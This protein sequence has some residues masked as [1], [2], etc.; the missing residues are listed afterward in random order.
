MLLPAFIIF[1]TESVCAN[2]ASLRSSCECR[3]VVSSGG[4]GSR[5]GQLRSYES[6][7]YPKVIIEGDPH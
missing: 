2:S 7:R 5:F 4:W 1:R 3:K 6:V